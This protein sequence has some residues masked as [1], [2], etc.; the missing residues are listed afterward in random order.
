MMTTRR[1]PAL[2]QDE[3]P[4]AAGLAGAIGSAANASLETLT[5]AGAGMAGYSFDDPERL[6][7]HWTSTTGV[8][9]RGLRIG[10]MSETTRESALDL[11]ASSVLKTDIRSRST[12]CHCKASWDAILASFTS[13]SSEN[14]AAPRHGA[15]DSRD[16]TFPF[17]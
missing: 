15:G 8:P 7:W 2:A 9:R 1:A 3:Q 12:L 10:D 5:E 16:T 17:T 13:R 14:P 4:S 6:F 11:L